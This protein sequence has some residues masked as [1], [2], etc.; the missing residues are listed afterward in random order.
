MPLTDPAAVFSLLDREIW[1]LTARAGNRRAG[2]VVTL[3]SQASIVLEG[4][5][6]WVGLSPQHHT[7]PVVRDGQSF[8]LHLVRE[9]HFDLVWKFG[10]RSGHDENKF[11]GAEWEESRLGHPRRPDSVAWLECIVE[12]Q[13]ETGDRLFFLARVCEAAKVSD[14]LPL[15]LHKFQRMLSPEQGRDL[16]RQLAHDAFIDADLIRRWNDAGYWPLAISPHRAISDG[17]P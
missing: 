10:T 5:R 6:V 15:T 13:A 1:L 2:L 3:V 9:S 4:P 8:L 17:A 7:T 11:A 16:K 14:D 12:S